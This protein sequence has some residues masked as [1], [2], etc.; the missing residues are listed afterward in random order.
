[1]STENVGVK[2]GDAEKSGAKLKAHDSFLARVM[3]E[4]RAQMAAQRDVGGEDKLRDAAHTHRA[5]TV[6]HRLR[7]ALRSDEK[8]GDVNRLK[9]IAE[10]K[11]R[12]PSKGVINER[13]DVAELAKAYERGGA[14]AVSVLTEEKYFGGSIDD[15]RAARRATSLPLLR[16][17]FIVDAYQIYEAAVA[18]A[19]TILLIVAA[20]S[21]KELSNLRQVAEDELGM[22]ALVEVHDEIELQT[23]LAAGAQLVGVNNRDLRTLEVSI[24]T[25]LELIRSLKMRKAIDDTITLISESG[26]SAPED[27]RRL[28]AAGFRG[29]LVGETLMRSDDP[30]ETLRALV[31]AVETENSRLSND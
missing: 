20:L 9:I 8:H 19:D 21:A 26:L 13:I 14:C 12:S 10:I 3:G 23:A 22:D 4:R 18:G 5:G 11:R 31:N 2:L 27:F 6:A 7:A 16:K 17:D 29:F 30:Q 15:L 1:M 24:E 25:S 28:H